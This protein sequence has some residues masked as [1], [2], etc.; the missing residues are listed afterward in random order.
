VPG[1]EGVWGGEAIV[2]GLL[3]SALASHELTDL[4]FSCYIAEEAYRYL[5]DR[6]LCRNQGWSGS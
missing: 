4:R 2:P 6:S 3:S 1:F 5:S